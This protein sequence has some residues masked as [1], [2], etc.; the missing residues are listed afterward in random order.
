M[1]A[2]S[3]ATTQVME[4]TRYFLDFPNKEVEAAFEAYLHSL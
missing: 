1:E 4:R 3:K 2:I